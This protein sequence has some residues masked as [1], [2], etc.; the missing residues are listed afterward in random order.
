[1]PPELLE[2]QGFRATSQRLHDK[3]EKQE[4]RNRPRTGRVALTKSKSGSSRS[5]LLPGAFLVAVR[6]Q[7]F[8]ALMFIDLRF[9]ALFQ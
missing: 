8:A 7:L 1:M 6:P 3:P 4:Q 9:T 2:A 5:L